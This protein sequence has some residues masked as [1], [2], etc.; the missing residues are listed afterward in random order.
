VRVCILCVH[1][2]FALMCCAM[3]VFELCVFTLCV[4]GQ[5]RIVSVLCVLGQCRIVSVDFLCAYCACIM[6]VHIMCEFCDYKLC[7]CIPCA[8]CVCIMYWVGGFCVC[9]VGLRVV[10][11]KCVLCVCVYLFTMFELYCVGI[12]FVCIEG[13]SKVK[14]W[15]PLV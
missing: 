1:C 11:S 15:F 9:I 2:V 4:L 6:S 8:L 5:C 13:Y 14:I 7:V 10:H 12:E 3:R